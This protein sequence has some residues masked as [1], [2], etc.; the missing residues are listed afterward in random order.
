MRRYTDEFV[1]KRTFDVTDS[2]TE[3]G[4]YV[5]RQIVTPQKVYYGEFTKLPNLAY[6][7]S[8]APDAVQWTRDPS[9]ETFA[10]T[11]APQESARLPDGPRV[12]VE[13]VQGQ[14]TP[15]APPQVTTGSATIS[16]EAPQ[17]SCGDSFCLKSQ[18]PAIAMEKGTEMKAPGALDADLAA[19]LQLNETLL[20]A[21]EL[22]DVDPVTARV[23]EQAFSGEQLVMDFGVIPYKLN[24]DVRTHGQESRLVAENGTYYTT[25]TGDVTGQGTY[26]YMHGGLY[27][28]DYAKPGLEVGTYEIYARDNRTGMEVAKGTP[29]ES[30]DPNQEYWAGSAFPSGEPTIALSAEPTGERIPTTETRD[31]SGDTNLEPNLTVAG[32]PELTAEFKTPIPGPQSCTTGE[33]LAVEGPASN[34]ADLLTSGCP[35]DSAS[36]EL[37]TSHKCPAMLYCDD[38][39]GKM[40]ANNVVIQEAPPQAKLG[41]LLVSSE[42]PAGYTFSGTEQLWSSVFADRSEVPMSEVGAALEPFQEPFGGVQKALAGVARYDAL[43]DSDG[44]L[45][46]SELLA[47]RGPIMEAAYFGIKPAYFGIPE[48]RAPGMVYCDDFLG[49]MT[50]N[51]VVIQEAPP[52]AKLGLLLAS[53]E[54][55]AGYTFSGTE[56]LWSSVFADRSEVPMSEVG[57]ALEPF[58]E[59]FGGVQKAL[60]GAARYDALGDSDGN[61]DKSELLA[62]REP[63]MEAAFS[64]IKPEERAPGMVYCD[65]FLGK[66][67]ANNVVIQ[68]APPQAKLGLLLASSENP[69]GYTFSGTEQLW[70]SVFADRSEVPMSEVGAALEPFQEPFGGVQK[71]LAGAARYD[72]LGDSD[73]NLDKSELLA[74]REPIME[75]AFSGIKPEERA[76][77]MVYCDDFLGKMTAN[78]VAI[79]EAPPQ[80]KLGLLLASSENPAGYTFSG[81]EELWSSVFAGRS[82]V[83][84][85]EVG[86]ALEPFQEPFGGIQKALEGAA[87]YD[88]LGDGDGNLDKSELLACREPIMEAAFSGIKPEERA[89]GMV[90]C[91]DFLGKMTANNVAIQEAPPQTK[92]GLLLASSENPAGYTFSGTEELWSSVFAGRSE[93]PMSEV[94]VALE[95]FQEPFGGIQKALEGAARYDALG[96]GDGNLDKSELLAC[97]EPITEAAYFGMKTEPEL[98]EVSSSE[99]EPAPE[100]GTWPEPAPEEGTGPELEPLSSPGPE[101]EEG[102]EPGFE[103]GT[104]PRFE[105]DIGF[106]HCDDLVKKLETDPELQFLPAPVKL[107]MVLE[108]ADN[109]MGFAFSGTEEIWAG[110][111]GDAEEISNDALLYLEEI[112]QLTS[113]AYNMVEL[114]DAIGDR[115]GNLD[116]SEFLH[117]ADPIPASGDVGASYLTQDFRADQPEEA[118]SE[119]ELEVELAEDAAAEDAAAAAAELAAADE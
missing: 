34:A 78:N 63:I 68:E 19:G 6:A 10:G 61:L 23:T 5:L 55:P 2:Y 85:S 88:A 65:D 43:G 13:G 21:L 40:T 102:I 116:K 30:V 14:W 16:Y 37:A 115:D 12:P 103:E 60:A 31:E 87:R 67:T 50:A 51:N 29:A 35:G 11:S 3:T 54:N 75:A 99:P 52:Q 76:P 17:Q 58:Q 92:L 44:N 22:N 46:K 114:Y 111:F 106:V 117:C 79:Q 71:A 36:C 81:T 94:G 62:C 4:G 96:D 109:E 118:A 119:A 25:R 93:V 9:S 24:Y 97:R 1:E 66:M 74:C 104:G 32:E 82:E 45:D 18:L 49:K 69:A 107:S 47:C 98:G 27:I 86:V 56:Q 100:E 53:S 7:Q 110:T 89:P 48:E 42:N 112:G 101:P 57:A 33:C 105:D 70:S 8:P 91:D 77:G 39:L 72:A 26:K 113:R 41:L 73:G 90:Y 15:I 64:G 80:T 83:P 20:R 95:P 108:S 84:M 38:F 28:A 59:P